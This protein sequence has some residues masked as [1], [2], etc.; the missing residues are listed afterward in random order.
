M[1]YRKPFRAKPI[2]LGAYAR[3]QKWRKRR[4]SLKNAAFYI[5]CGG[6]ML[7]SGM[8]LTSEKERD[9]NAYYPN[10]SAARAAGAAPINWDEPGYRDELDRDN[11]GV[12][13]EPYPN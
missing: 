3:Q 5:G 9:P 7:A 6:A 1:G 12:A 2:V 13:C 11:D 4:Q 10:C 8:Y